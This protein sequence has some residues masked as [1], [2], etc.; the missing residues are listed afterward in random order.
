MNIK[1]LPLRLELG[2]WN[3]TIYLLSQ[4]RWL[5]NLLPWFYREITLRWRAFTR[6]F[7]ARLALAWASAGL[8]LG[9]I[10]GFM[11]ALPFF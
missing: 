9:F 11:A 5:Q 1:Q 8:L 4:S 3:L 7:D 2:F 6:S 10:G